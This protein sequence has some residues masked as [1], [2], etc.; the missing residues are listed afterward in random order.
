ME[1]GD[2]LQHRFYLKMLPVPEHTGG[3]SEHLSPATWNPHLH[4]KGCGAFM[5]RV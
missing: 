4:L 3:S 2:V 1:F 5:I